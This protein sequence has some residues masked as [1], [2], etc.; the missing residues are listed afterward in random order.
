[1]RPVVVLN[2]SEPAFL[3]GLSNLHYIGFVELLPDMRSVET[4][5]SEHLHNLHQLRLW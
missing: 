5:T 2:C 3:R 4:N 1:M